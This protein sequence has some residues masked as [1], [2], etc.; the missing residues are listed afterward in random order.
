MSTLKYRVRTIAPVLISSGGGSNV[1]ETKEYIPGRMLLGVFAAKYIQNVLNE[2]Q[3]PAHEDKDFYKYFLQGDIVFSNAYLIIEDS[4]KEIELLPTPLSIQMS[5]ADENDFF[6]L[7]REEVDETTKAL[8]KYTHFSSDKGIIVD[9]PKKRL[10]FHHYREDR[11]R[12]HGTGGGIFNYEALAEGQLFGGTISGEEK[13]L[14]RFKKKFGSKFSARIGRSRNSQYGYVEIELLEIENLLR[15]KARE[16]NDKIKAGQNEVVL[17]FI[18]PLILVNQ[19]GFPEVSLEILQCYLEKFFN[20]NTAAEKFRIEKCFTRI[21]RIENHVAVW[22]LKRPLDMA[23]SEGS[24][25]KIKFKKAI[26][27][28]LERKLLNLAVHGL[29]ERRNEG[30]GQVLLRPLMGEKYERR[31]VGKKREKKPQNNPPQL[32]KTIFVAIIKKNITESAVRKALSDSRDV[33]LFG[34]KL[35]NNLV[36]RLELMLKAAEGTEVFV[37][38]LEKL[39]QTAQTALKSCYGRDSQQTLWEKLEKTTKKEL[40]DDLYRKSS[41]SIRGITSILEFKSNFDFKNETRFQEEIYKKYWL[42]Y[43]RNIRRKNKEI[44]K[45][46]KE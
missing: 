16:T 43:L 27:K 39:Q 42:A 10:N 12:G 1:T 24:A 15:N 36:G 3:L 8:G 31:D 46:G 40:I 32:V 41:L 33:C 29:G 18:S 38:A 17:T 23:F 30:F 34:G 13:D 14:C 5:K 9:L 22:R 25:F 45:K 2:K 44:K 35:S 7:M 21:E 26:D 28:E 11:I 19:Y 37:Q 4:K 20:C 6:N